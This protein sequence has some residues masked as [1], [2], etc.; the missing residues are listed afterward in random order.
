MKYILILCLFTIGCATTYEA[1]SRDYIEHQVYQCR[2][3]CSAGTVDIAAIKGLQCECNTRKGDTPVIINNIPQ[4]AP[5]YIDKTQSHISIYPKEVIK[6]Q[7]TQAYYID[8]PDSSIYQREADIRVKQNATV[9][10]RHDGKKIYSQVR[11]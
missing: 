5:Y 4:P 9:V 6:Q 11:Q 2:R 1:G 7:D 10:E 3:L 8:K